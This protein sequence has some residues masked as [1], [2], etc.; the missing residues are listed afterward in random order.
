MKLVFEG[1]YTSLPLRFFIEDVQPVLRDAKDGYI[2]YGNP[3]P[4]P[5]AD[6]SIEDVINL[7][8][9]DQMHSVNIVRSSFKEVPYVAIISL[10]AD[11]PSSKRDLPDGYGDYDLR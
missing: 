8:K 7:F 9:I 3:V 10:L 2:S 6:V 4:V 1:N 5:V 11:I